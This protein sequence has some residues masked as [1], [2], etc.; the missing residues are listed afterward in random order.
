MRLEDLS[1]PR[2][3]P[4]TAEAA[5]NILR[6]LGLTWQQPVLNQVENL[7]PYHDA[8]L[9][10][11]DKAVVY[12]S[13]HSRKQIEEALAAPHA[14]EHELIFPTA[15]RPP[16]DEMPPH[17]PPPDFFGQESWNTAWRLRVP[18][19]LI[20]FKDEL[21]G[22]HSFNL[23]TSIGDFI[24]ATRS[25]MPAY[26]LAVVVDDARQ[27]VTDV[28]RGSD[29]LSSTPRQLYLYELLELPAP[30][31][32]WHLPMVIG[33][34]GRRLAKRHGDTRLATYRDEHQ[35]EPNRI[36]GLLGYWCRM[37]T[38]L[39]PMTLDEFLENLDLERL[40]RDTI[41]FKQEQHQWLIS[42]SG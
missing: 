17:V 37:T 36:L 8:L 33:E 23:A 39:S 10:L 7:K 19:R 11:Y 24:V 6:W 18:D 2:V 3:K 1:G 25:G 42:D 21:L 20:W 5:L 13:P 26:Q 4:E 9:K 31:R 34:D 28:I 41:T 27:G 14:D 22:P 15:L 12:P 38:A 40:P 35:I 29:L 32:W 30:K 16:A